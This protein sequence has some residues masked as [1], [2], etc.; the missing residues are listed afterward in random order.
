[1]LHA[2]G[3]MLQEHHERAMGEPWPYVTSWWVVSFLPMAVVVFAAMR[4][5]RSGPDD[6][7]RR[8]R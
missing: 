3:K 2:L 7:N 5:N 8:R 1:M 4:A 6:N